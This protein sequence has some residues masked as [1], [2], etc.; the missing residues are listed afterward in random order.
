ML[1]LPYLP[2]LCIPICSRRTQRHLN[3]S[4]RQLVG[5]CLSLSLGTFPA[6]TILVDLKISARVT[7]LLI[8][9]LENDYEYMIGGQALTLTLTS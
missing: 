9:L 1:G 5:G 8:L 3:G 6:D 4:L 7:S 2:S